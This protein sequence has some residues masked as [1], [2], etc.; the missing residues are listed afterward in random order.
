MTAVAQN[1][2]HF[3]KSQSCLYAVGGTKQKSEAIGKR[4]IVK[5]KSKA[6]ITK[7]IAFCIMKTYKKLHITSLLFHKKDV[8]QSPFR[9]TKTLW[10]LQKTFNAI[11]WTKLLQFLF[12]S[13][14]PPYIRTYITTKINIKCKIIF[15]W[16]KNLCDYHWWKICE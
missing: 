11:H 14:S 8:I 5:K 10:Y 16:Y 4:S 2:Y 12:W 3:I 15:R 9:K 13:L 7:I 1:L 6:I